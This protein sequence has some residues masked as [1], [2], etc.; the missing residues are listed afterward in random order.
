DEPV[1]A[2]WREPL[3]PPDVEDIHATFGPF[4]PRLDPADE[5]VPK[6]DRQDVPAPAA[7]S[8]WHEELPHVVEVEQAPKEAA[9]PNQRVER[10]E[11][12]DRGRWLRGRFQQFDVLTDEQA[13]SADALHVDGN[14]VSAVD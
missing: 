11:E 8:G 10:W 3:L 1:H 7:F 14:E 13:L 12:G 9:I 5:A 2:A 4:D 6:D